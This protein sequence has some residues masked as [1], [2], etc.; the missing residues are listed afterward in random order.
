MT[1]GIRHRIGL[2]SGGPIARAAAGAGR[3]PAVPAQPDPLDQIIAEKAAANAAQARA[4]ARAA[5]EAVINEAVD[6]AIRRQLEQEYAR[7]WPDE[8]TVSRYKTHMASFVKFAQGRGLGHLPATANVV[9][10][11]LIDGAFATDEA[12]DRAAAIRFCHAAAECWLDPVPI[13]A[14]ISFLRQADA[15]DVAE[16]AEAA[17]DVRLPNGNGSHEQH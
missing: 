11:Y 17:A 2:A 12:S 16:V 8:A 10:A 1:T 4:D 5:R 15:D 3:S 9:A 6:N 14:A 13:A 7:E